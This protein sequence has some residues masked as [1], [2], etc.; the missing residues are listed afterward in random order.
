M[1]TFVVYCTYRSWSGDYAWGPRFFVWLV[2]V[3]LVPM[4]WFVDHMSR[5]KRAFAAAIVAGGICVQLLGISLYWDH[6]IRVA[7]AAKNQWLGNPNRK[8]SYI[9]ERGR[10][11]C[12]S[13]FEDTYELTWTPAFQ[14]IRGQWWLLKSLA[15]GDDAVAAQVDAPWRTYTSLDINLD[16]GLRP[17]A[18]RL[19]GDAVVEGHAGDANARPRDV[20]PHARRHGIR[21]ERDGCGTIGRSM[22]LRLGPEPA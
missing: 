9:A 7:I 16:S 10:G 11:H 15:R 21:R 4:A 2:P 14:P 3:L 17:H 18:T 19:V 20:D 22:T 6:Y 12:D 1:P 8:G 5:W 13:C